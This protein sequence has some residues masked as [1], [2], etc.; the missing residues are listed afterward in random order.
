MDNQSTNQHLDFSVLDPNTGL[1]R[2][3][4]RIR[5]WDPVPF[6]PLDPGSG[7]SKK[8]RSGSGIQDE[9]LGSYFWELRNNFWGYI[10][11]C[12]SGSE[13]Q[14]LFTLDPE[15]EK[16]R[17]RDPEWKKNR[18]RDPEWKTRHRGG[19][20]KHPGSATPLADDRIWILNYLLAYDLLNYLI[21]TNCLAYAILYLNLAKGSLILYQNI[22]TYERLG[23]TL[24]E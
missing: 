3:V 23:A 22:L 13:I 19:G 4:L 9:H 10:L 11:W 15:W 7:M 21:I 8:S 16:N 6:W 2:I 17:I 12:G 5:I 1:L 18:I 14:N 24:S 20:D